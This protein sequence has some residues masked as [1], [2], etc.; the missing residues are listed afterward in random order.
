MLLVEDKVNMY[1]RPVLDI[2]FK[3]VHKGKQEIKGIWY[4]YIPR[5]HI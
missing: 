4:I 1:S 5:I 3:D 2:L